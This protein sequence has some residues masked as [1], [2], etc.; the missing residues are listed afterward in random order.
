MFLY[1]FLCGN[2]HFTKIYESNIG[3]LSYLGGFKELRVLMCGSCG[4]PSRPQGFVTVVV[5]KQARIEMKEGK[6][7]TLTFLLSWVE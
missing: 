4:F 5:L 6:S 2:D 3:V 1:S 7:V